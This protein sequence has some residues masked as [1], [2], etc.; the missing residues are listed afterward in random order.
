[1]SFDLAACKR[2]HTRLQTQLRNKPEIDKL[3][4][5]RDAEDD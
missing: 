4:T 2:D 5:F 1:V 3:Y